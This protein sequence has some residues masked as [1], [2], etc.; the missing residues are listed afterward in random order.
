MSESIHLGVYDALTV[1]NDGG[2]ITASK[3]GYVDSAAKVLDLGAAIRT[4]GKAIFNVTAAGTASGQKQTLKIQVSDDNFASDIVDVA[5][6][7]LG[8]AAQVPGDTDVGTGQYEV[9]FHNSPAG[10][11]KRYVR[12]YAVLTTAS[13]VPTLNYTCHLTV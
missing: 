7:E 12:C 13:P 1:L 5:I 8:D 9:P 10:T 3:A 2:A 4:T 11:P 6:L